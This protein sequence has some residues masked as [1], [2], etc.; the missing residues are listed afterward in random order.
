MEAIKEEKAIDDN[1]KIKEKHPPG[2]YLLF[3]T[4][5]W[6]RFSYYGMRGL[7]TLY[8]TTQFVKGG[9]G[10]DTA[11][12]A[13]IYGVFT[14]LVFFTPT[15]G[16]YIADRFLG[17]RKSIIIG[18]F[19]MALGQLT[20]FAKQDKLF[21]YIGLALLII[22]NG[23][24]KSNISTIV[25]ELYSKNDK[26]RDG[27]FTIFYMGINL[28]SFLAPL[29][30]GTL[31]EKWLATRFGG[32][33]IHYGFKY[34][35][36][37]AAI[38]IVIG[39]I[40]FITLSNKYLGDIGKYAVGKAKGESAADANKPLT[41]EEKNRT[42]VILILTAF[43]VF[44]WAGFEQAGTSLTMYAQNAVN[45][46]LGSMEVPITWF[47]SLNP[48]FVILFAPILAKVWIN[49]AK[50][51]K[52]LSIPSKMALGMLLL[53]SGYVLLV[54]AL[55][56]QGV[57]GTAVTA[58]ANMI[59]LVGVYFL[60]TLGELCLSPIGLSMVSKLAPVKLA[61]FLMGVWLSGQFLANIIGNVFIAAH[62]E[63]LGYLQIFGS[64]GIAAIVLGLILFSISKKLTKMM[65]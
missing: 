12:A 51:N 8:L 4:E 22:G 9:L 56:G 41:K 10:F 40:A 27:A 63:S 37:A 54:L 59:W 11:T 6:E 61:S 44:F 1:S 58:K 62:L 65:K 7:L 16:G 52:D 5:M 33:I 2:L 46:N 57:N 3:F 53:G 60:H 32:E 29:I 36:L 21:L 38:G 45:R 18:G 43:V 35:F 55:L 47:Q 26:R 39:Q 28:G 19:T 31:A 14:A 20:L 25:G 34:G 49:L 30:C 42:I 17:Q 15:I 23:F 50:D 24:F 48:L 64:I 13:Q